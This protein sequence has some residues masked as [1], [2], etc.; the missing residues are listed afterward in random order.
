M[1]LWW[2]STV[3]L[4]LQRFANGVKPTKRCDVI[5]LMHHDQYLHCWRSTPIT[6]LRAD[7]NPCSSSPW[8][9]GS[10]NTRESRV[11]VHE[12]SAR[13]LVELLWNCPTLLFWSRRAMCSTRLSWHLLK[14]ETNSFH[15]IYIWSLSSWSGI[16]SSFLKHQR[17]KVSILDLKSHQ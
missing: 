8:S 11:L 10:P 7:S 15:N 12:A 3:P 14:E 4:C 17:S 6:T 9:C 13:M 16:S 5:W 1:Q 2:M